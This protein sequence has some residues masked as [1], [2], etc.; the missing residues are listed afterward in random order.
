MARVYR[1]TIR[2]HHSNGALIEPSLHYQTDVPTTGDEPNPDD[3]AAGAWTLLGTAFK[4]C[5]HSSITVDDVVAAEEV[6][7]PDIGVGGA[8]TVNQVGTMSSA[9]AS[10]THGLVAVINRHTGIRSRSAR[11]WLM[12]PSPC[13]TDQ[14]N[15]DAWAA[16]GTY[17]LA[18]D[19]FALLLDNS[20]DLGSI[21][22]T[23]VN[24]VVYSRTRRA[25]GESP[26]VF[27]VT[28]ATV[29]PQA[30]FLHSRLSVP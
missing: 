25:R 21:L 26:W 8:H 18:L 28:S 5:C 24:P 1:V 16:S 27:R 29:N 23:N 4:A 10:E 9:S 12:M 2:A 30:R 19:A 17:K 14:T 13:L 11:G 20:F 3:V 6:L 22:V 15:G 7:K